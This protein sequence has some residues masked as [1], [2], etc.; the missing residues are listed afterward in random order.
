MLSSFQFR[1]IRIV[2]HQSLLAITTIIGVC[3]YYLVVWFV[4]VGTRNGKALVTLYEPPRQLSPAMLRYIWKETF[5]DRTFWAGVLN[6]VAKGLATLHSNNG[7]AFIRATSI[8]NQENSLPLEEKILWDDLV[9]GHTR[10]D[11]A[12]NMLN[13][14]TTLAITDMAEALH[15][16]AVGRWFQENRHIAIGGGLL[17]VAALCVAA[18]PRSRDQWGALILGLAVMAPGAFYLFFISQR[19]WDVIRAAK[20]HCDWTILRREAMLMTMLLPCVAAIILSGVVVGATFG[21]QVFAAALLL[22]VL[23]VAFLRWMKLPTDEGKQVLAEIEGFR[24]FLNSVERLPMGRADQ[25]ADHAGVYEKY[26][27]YAVAL[28]VEQAWGDRLMALTSTFHENAS[29]PGAEAFYLGMWN[30]K[31]LEASRWRSS[32][33]RKHRGV[34]HGERQPS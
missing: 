31:P 9:R 26:L 30:G 15:R 29:D 8:A 11:I 32:T 22:A 3:S 4:F 20:L 12:V 1:M 6:L 19:I 34:A 28:E 2:T 5:D 27:P 24:D 16:E 21:W 33:N 23:N 13:P 14:K 7:V 18:S 10:K 25:P 17:S